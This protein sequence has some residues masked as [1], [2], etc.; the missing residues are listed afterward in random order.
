MEGFDPAT[1]ADD[2]FKY[3]NQ[4]RTEPEEFAKHVQARLD[5]YEG[6]NYKDGAGVKYQSVEGKEA[7]ENAMVSINSVKG[8]SALVRS[9]GLDRAAKE[10]ADYNAETGEIGHTGKDGSTMG[11]RVEAQ[12][13]WT[14]K[15]GEC[16]GVQST[17]GLD[18]VLQW[19]IDD[20]IQKRG[21][22]QT[23]INK[24]F[25]KVGVAAAKHKT[26]GTIAVA[27]FATSFADEGETLPEP[28]VKE[29]A[30]LIDSLPEELKGL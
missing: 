16:V 12:G 2:I 15:V 23:I 5:T 11:K 3:M 7:P 4:V 28:E 21:D 1:V 29:N 10:L 14:G 18:Y 6:K 8:R 20:G 24:E 17:S 25:T 27:V 26:Y 19:F 22:R 30:G 9:A 13:K